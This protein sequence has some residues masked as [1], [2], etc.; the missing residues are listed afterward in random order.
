M[1][2]ESVSCE[3]YFMKNV[4]ALRMSDWW[5]LKKLSQS[6]IRLFPLEVETENIL[7]VSKAEM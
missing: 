7:V 5:N 2:I 6:I 1:E 4:N 3:E